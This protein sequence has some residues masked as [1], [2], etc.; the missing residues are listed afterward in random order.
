VRVRAFKAAGPS[1]RRVRAS[2]L[3]EKSFFAAAAV[4][5]F[6]RI[7]KTGSD[8][9]TGSIDD[10]NLDSDRLDRRTIHLSHLRDPVTYDEH[11]GLAERVGTVHLAIKDQR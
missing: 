3:Q 2:C 11:I 10:L 7:D 9:T 4:K 5:V 6:V 1:T 8:Y